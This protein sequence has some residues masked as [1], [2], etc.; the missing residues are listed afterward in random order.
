MKLKSTKLAGKVNLNPI[1]YKSVSLEKSQVSDTGKITGYLSVFGK[2]DSD[3]DILIKGCFARSISDRGPQSNTNRKIAFL[4][5]HDMDDPIGQFTMLKEDD[6]GLYFEAE[7]D[8]GVTSADR[9]KLQLKSGTLNQFSVGFQ[10]IWD[11]MEYDD[12]QEACII[13]EVN[14]FEG[15]VV[16]LG[17]NEYTYY[18]GM[19]GQVLIDKKKE[20]IEDTET[21]INSFPVGKRF[22]LRQLISKNINMALA[23]KATP[24]DPDNDQEPDNTD[25]GF[26]DDCTAIHQSALDLMDSYKDDMESADLTTLC[27]TM[28]GMHTDCMQK[29]ENIKNDITGNKSLNPQTDND[30]AKSIQFVFDS[31]A[32]G[33]QK[34]LFQ[35]V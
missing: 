30:S 33:E 25:V 17:A 16:T 1:Q 5:Q 24:A 11:Q 15:S 32:P 4:W 10:Y 8:A 2:V 22:E 28:K 12:T 31:V 3:G 18:A 7:L 34:Q 35:F 26:I 13:K 27:E 19:K 21:L 20:L 14:L 9:A 23:L 6:Y 29:M